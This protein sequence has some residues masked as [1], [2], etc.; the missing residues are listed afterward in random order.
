MEPGKVFAIVFDGIITQRLVELSAEKGVNLVIGA[1]MGSKLSYKP[2]N[3]RV[4]TFTDI[5]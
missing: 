2:P 3:L 5:T 1:R 4:L